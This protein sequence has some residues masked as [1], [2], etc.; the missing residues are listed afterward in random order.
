[1]SP[2]LTAYA[3]GQLFYYIAAG[4][5]TGAVTLNIDGL[6]AKA[7]TRDGSTALAAGDIN[8]GE[9]VV[10][11]YD[12]TRFQM[13]NAANSFGNTTINGTLTVTGNTGLQAN[14]SI[15]STLSVGGTFA[16]TGA[17]TLGSTLA[18]TG[19]A[20]L[21]TVST[22]SINAAVAV[23]TTGTVTNLTSTSASIASVNAGVALLT[24][25]TV[26]DLT[27]SGASIASANI[28]NL[29]FTAA[30]IASI[31]AGVA[32]VTNLT[33]TSASIASANVGTAVI[34]TGTV[35]NLASTSA[36]IASANAAV[37]LV[38]TGTV[39]N[40]TST[41]ASIASANLGTAVVTT[42]TVTN[43]TA[44]SASIA[45][46][47]AGTA[48]V[49]NLTATG[50]S[51]ASAN[52]GT[53]VVTALTV[54]GASVA[55]ANVGTA[56]IT[57][58]TATGASVASIN[59][60][61]ALVTTGTV[62]NLTSTTASIASA[63]IG[64][65]AIGTLSF[66]GASIASLNA[67]TATITTG[68][69]TFS[70]TGQR[71]TGDMSTATFSNRLAFQ[72]STANSATS[73][74]SLPNGTG[75][76]SNINCYNNSDPTNSSL[77]LA[78]TNATE[79]LI[80]SAI[81]GTGTYLPMTF[82][83][84]GSERMRLDTS[85][86]L[87]IGTASPTTGYKLSVSAATASNTV[88]GGINI[89]SN[90]S[91]STSNNG[92]IFSAIAN[93]GTIGT[94]DFG[95]L[96]FK[97]APN[98]NGA[99]AY[100][101]MFAGGASTTQ[102]AANKFLEGYFDGSL[103]NYVAAYTNGSERMRIDS[104]GNV[105]IGGTAAAF[106]KTEVAGNLPSS[107][108]VSIA[109]RNL[110]TVP[111]GTT[112]AAY[113]FNSHLL[114]Q[115]ASFTCSNFYHFFSYQNSIGAGSAVTNQYGYFVDSSLTG[116]TNNY[117]FFSNIASGTNRWNFYAAGTAQ[118]YF[119]GNTGVGVTPNS[120]VRFK[121]AGSDA[122]GS[123]YAF[124]ATNSTPADLFW[125]RNDGE[126]Y[127]GTAASSPY[128]NTTGSAANVFVTVNG[129]LQR[130]TSSLRYKTNVANASHGLADVLKL[131]SVTYKSKNDK[132]TV[133]GGLIAEEV[134][135]AGLTEFVAYDNEGRPDAL[136]YGNMVALL[137]KAVQELKAELEALKA[138]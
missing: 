123:N 64:V 81:R 128:N 124:I 55:S 16:V 11:I 23:V 113:G 18:V 20:D 108:N 84:G 101:Q 9:I 28:G 52:V 115:A 31:N 79:A 61:V 87:G 106:T 74:S 8:S 7:V 78:G 110:G 134:H 93:N 122:T 136:H 68:N 44:T 48:V 6:G 4:A 62:T 65:A 46:A 1:M 24:T 137:V 72:T 117:G 40:L 49:T 45:S 116:A 118:N 75:T 127:T 21:P 99:S 15:T 80:Q 89:Q 26:T 29:Q 70:S 42:G 59:A 30:S 39:T 135:D 71:I 14:V 69:L 13:I 57:T 53:G 98:S 33:A 120:A 94:H 133:F 103:M 107:S 22:A 92:V 17:A 51:I 109:F 132:D 19:K 126:I 5:N 131:R 76:A 82:Y 102:G 104:S 112:G 111:S 60:G 10:V 73:I 38:T 58:L 36:S 95:A 25:A 3:A 56:V 96:V 83:T 130:S 85:G 47:N 114:T 67:G 125:V 119:A 66:T 41:S 121:V 138:V 97:E 34:T 77:L 105:G 2:T 129:I 32:V 43:L 54:T 50:A 90:R 100:V 37:A 63:N 35:T 88:T 27:A 91:Y 86:N 12:G